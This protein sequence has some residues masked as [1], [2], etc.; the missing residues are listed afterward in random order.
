MGAALPSLILPETS[1]GQS[2]THTPTPLPQLPLPASFHSEPH[3]E[4]L[5]FLS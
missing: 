2:D 5:R 1:W 3:A 4:K